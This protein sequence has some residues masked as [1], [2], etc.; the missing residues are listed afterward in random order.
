LL[1]LYLKRVS[2]FGFNADW[3]QIVICDIDNRVFVCVCLMNRRIKNSRNGFT[4]GEAMMATIVLSIAAAGILLPYSG[5]AAVRAEGMRVTLGYKL[6][7]DLVEQILRSDFDQIVA[8]YDGYMESEGHVTDASGVE[9]TDSRY[10]K[11]SRSASCTYVYMPQ[12]SG[13]ADPRFILVTVEVC[14]GGRTIASV[15]RLVG[16]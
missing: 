15:K 7:A 12:E 8:S 4:L 3:Q 5:G 1:G 14:Y 11:L 16:Q 13:S 6:A 2:L 10:A 9:F